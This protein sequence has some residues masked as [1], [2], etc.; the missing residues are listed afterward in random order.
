M[1]V[2]VAA[3]WGASLE[4]FAHGG[5][6]RPA[7]AKFAGAIAG[8]RDSAAGPGNSGGRGMIFHGFIQAGG[9]STRFGTDKALVRLGDKT[10]LQRQGELSA[11]VCHDGTTSA[12]GGR[13]AN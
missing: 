11:D 8:V 10:M 9:G 1:R 13:C 3:A 7:P 6:H 2:F 12:P 4:Y 5:Y